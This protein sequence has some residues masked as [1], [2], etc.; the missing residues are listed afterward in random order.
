MPAAPAPSATDDPLLEPLSVFAPARGRHLRT[1]AL[2]AVPV[3]LALWG[4]LHGATLAQALQALLALV[5]ALHAAALLWLAVWRPA[6]LRGLPRDIR[7]VIRL[8]RATRQLN[9]R[10]SRTKGS[11]TTADFWAETVSRHGP[12]EALV[13]GGASWTYAEVDRESD[14]VA[15]W[16][17]SR[18]IAA[19]GGGGGSVALLCS[20]RPEHL[21]IWL[22][23]AK[24]GAATALLNPAL[25]GASISHALEQC[26]ATVLLFDADS[27]DALE[28]FASR[29]ALVC[30][31]A[32]RTPP[33]AEPLVLPADA[34]PPPASLRSSCRCTDTLLHIFTSGTTGLPKA[35]RLNHVRYFSA[36]VVP[37]MF[38]LKP[39]DRFY[40]CL[41]MCHTA[42]VGA[43]CFCWW[44]GIPL[45]LAPKFSATRFW[46]D[47]TELRATVVQY[48]GELCRYLVA[49]P[50]S[51]YDR[52]HSVRLAFGNGLR[53][54]V[55]PRFVRRF[56]VGR[57]AE[58]YASTEG[59][60]SLANTVGRE[61]AVGFIS[62]LLA[63][64][65]PVRLARVDADTGELERGSDGLCV[66]CAPGE[67]GELL[68]L[69]NQRD[70]ARNFAG[71]TDETATRRKLVR[72]VV[73]RGDCY[74]RTGDLM[75]ADADG[76]VSFVDRMGDTFRYKGEN[77]STAEVA[78]AIGGIDGVQHCLVYGVQLPGVDGR[79]GM[80]ALVLEAGSD[81]DG[82]MRRLFQT[83]DSE[84]PTY[85]APRFVRLLESA[86]AIDVTL[87]FKPIKATL[88]REGVAAGC[89]V[90]DA[91]SRTYVELDDEAR[92]QI[93]SGARPLH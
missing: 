73:R 78:A 7:F 54:E 26:G 31:D 62:P 34:P 68:G 88:Q 77:V 46:R 82:A 2:G 76:F 41:P 70:A 42:A 20:N 16:A 87:T 37:Y 45:L 8:V 5:V 13:F 89:L 50:P 29:A 91:G 66:L 48:V 49:S 60:A 93:L 6:L 3:L 36:I 33:F 43:C 52:A 25:R 79:V 18:G 1:V 28:G 64:M 92:R 53:P 56:G 19:G 58:V 24:L 23:V 32:H 71:Y 61:G 63:R 15:H 57:I 14:R 80:A 9:G 17:R 86:D 38:E 11:F 65:Y 10:L 51:E 47:A 30:I 83:V 12:K 81:R 39:T 90:R 44:L 21:F 40:C 55:W 27:A 74:F 84:L 22:G 69:V 72:S 75:R 35:A 67:A 4:H 59:N 85:A